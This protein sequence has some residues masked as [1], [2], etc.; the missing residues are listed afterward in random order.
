MFERNATP[1]P[2]ACL[3]GLIYPTSGELVGLKRDGVSFVWKTAAAD[4]VQRD[5]WLS[6]WMVG[7]SVPQTSL[8]LGS[9][10]ARLHFVMKSRKCLK[11][12]RNDRSPNM[13]G[14]P[15]EQPDLIR[16]NWI[17]ALSFRIEFSFD[18][19]LVIASTRLWR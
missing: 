9:H 16:T 19:V 15:E 3:L 4:S 17:V 2:D 12:K 8:P 10:A 5:E 11:T 18:R 14:S 6:D 13:F 7:R 1:V